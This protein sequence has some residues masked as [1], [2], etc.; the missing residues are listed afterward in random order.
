[1]GTVYPSKEYFLAYLQRSFKELSYLSP[2]L[3]DLFEGIGE[4]SARELDKCIYAKVCN[5]FEK[6][7]LLNYTSAK[8]LHPDW[9]FENDRPRGEKTPEMYAQLFTPNGEAEECNGFWVKGEA[10]KNGET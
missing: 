7:A 10:T 3:I 2:E 6:V 8:H 9:D 5:H 4:G 1:M